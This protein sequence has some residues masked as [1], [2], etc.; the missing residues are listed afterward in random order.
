MSEEYWR[1]LYIDTQRKLN[2]LEQE[3]QDYKD[4]VEEILNDYWLIKV[5]Y[6]QLLSKYGGE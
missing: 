2:E 5:K 6:K 4:E 1:N 3:Y